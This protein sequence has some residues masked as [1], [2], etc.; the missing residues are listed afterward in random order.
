MHARGLGAIKSKG[1]YEEII[2]RVENAIG[3]ERTKSFHSHFSRIEFTEGGEKST[4]P[5]LIQNMDQSFLY[6]AEVIIE[7]KLHSDNY[8]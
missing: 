8:L 1:D 4:G 3:Y 6:L 5:C 7:R 2:D